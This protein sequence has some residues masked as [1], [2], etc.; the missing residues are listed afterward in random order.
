[1]LS[2]RNVLCFLRLR[3]GLLPLQ[4]D[5]RVRP[6]GVKVTTS[7]HNPAVKLLRDFLILA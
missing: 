2:E 5:R 1:M 3:D 6:Q 7:E 4:G